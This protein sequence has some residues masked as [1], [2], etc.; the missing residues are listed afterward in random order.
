[1]DKVNLRMATLLRGL[2]V[3]IV[4]IT[5]VCEVNAQ[6]VDETR[7]K[8]D[9]AEMIR[10][11]FESKK[12][13]YDM[14]VEDTIKFLLGI[15]CENEQLW[16]AVFVIP[17][18]LRY[19]IL[20]QPKT[21]IPQEYIEYSLIPIND[22][23]HSS[24][25]VGADIDMADGQLNFGMGRNTDNGAFSKEAFIAD[26]RGLLKAADNETAQILKKAIALSKEA[27]K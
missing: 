27:S 26:F 11:Y 25:M 16:I 15:E 23:N 1:M 7:L 19:L 18:E 20:V 12:Y 8:D 5:S 9:V 22:F 24:F 3:F 2:L 10:Q 4:L 17:E 21:T 6:T 13:K 14:E